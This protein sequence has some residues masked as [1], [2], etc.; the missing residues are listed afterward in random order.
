MPSVGDSPAFPI[1]ELS[2]SHFD[3]CEKPLSN[4]LNAGVR[5]IVYKIEHYG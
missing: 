4:Y 3:G 5:Q 2:T 1:V